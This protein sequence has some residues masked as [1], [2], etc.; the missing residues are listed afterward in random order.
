VIEGALNHLRCRFARPGVSD[1]GRLPAAQRR[2][3]PDGHFHAD[4]LPLAERAHGRFALIVAREGA[5]YFAWRAAWF[6]QIEAEIEVSS[7]SSWSVTTATQLST[8]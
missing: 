1:R 8:N 5:D 3:G 6:R 2:A 4:I 7:D